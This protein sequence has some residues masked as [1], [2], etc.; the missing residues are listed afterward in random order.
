MLDALTAAGPQAMLG[1]GTLLAGAGA[2]SAS[3]EN[4]TIASDKG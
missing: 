3:E 1:Q 2:F 4:A